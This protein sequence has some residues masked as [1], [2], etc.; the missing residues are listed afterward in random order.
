MNRKIGTARVF[1]FLLISFI[2]VWVFPSYFE[3]NLFTDFSMRHIYIYILLCVCV[4]IFCLAT[5][6]DWLIS[7]NSFLLQCL[8][9]LMYKILTFENIGYLT[10]FFFFQIWGSLYLSLLLFSWLKLSKKYWR[11]AIVDIADLFHL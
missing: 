7:S 8:G 5:L 10:F 1:V 9:F 2:K 4:L 6:H 3:E 11:I